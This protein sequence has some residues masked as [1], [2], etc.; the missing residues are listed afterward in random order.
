MQFYLQLIS[1][2]TVKLICLSHIHSARSLGK[3]ALCTG[4]DGAGGKYNLS[5]IC[6]RGRRQLCSFPS[7]SFSLLR[8]GRQQSSF[9]LFAGNCQIC[10]IM[11]KISSMFNSST[12][13]SH[14]LQILNKIIHKET[15][16]HA[17][18]PHSAANQMCTSR[19]EQK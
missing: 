8:A 7:A 19:V 17:S 15:G 10:V 13:P 5:S 11:D 18:A 3:W 14:V 4:P 6:S 12:C 16:F 1:A 2:Y 9:I